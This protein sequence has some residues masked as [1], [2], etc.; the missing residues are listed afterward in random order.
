MSSFLAT[1]VGQLSDW[2]PRLAE[3]AR[4][5]ALL[6]ILGYVTAFVIGLL[7]HV[8]SSRR[9]GAVRAFARLYI[10]LMRG[11]PLLVILYLLYFALPGAGLTLDAVTAGIAG[12]ALVY[13]A[14]IA[15][16]F[17]AGFSAVAAGQKEAAQAVGLSPWQTFRV[18]LLPQAL[19]HVLAPLL[20]T[21]IS[22]MKDSS[23]C[24]LIS[25]SELTLASREIMSESFLP[26]HVFAVTATIYFSIAFPASRLVAVLDRKLSEPRRRGSPSTVAASPAAAGELSNTPPRPL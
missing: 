18:I 5:T 25:V 17:R 10:T 4:M 23:V 8:L 16:V 3:A 11:I 26:L 21:L 7:I 6:T 2:G 24:A 1:I 20:V 19:R 9:I 13:G 15:E 12:L 14:Y 22:L